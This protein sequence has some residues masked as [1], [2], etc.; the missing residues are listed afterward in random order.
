MWKTDW[1]ADGREVVP[2]KIGNITKEP[3]DSSKSPTCE[4]L[5]LSVSKDRV[6]DDQR[7]IMKSTFKTT[8]VGILM[9]LKSTKMYGSKRKPRGPW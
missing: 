1:H 5:H 4:S 2:A 9:C 7:H 6:Q 8:L 3:Y